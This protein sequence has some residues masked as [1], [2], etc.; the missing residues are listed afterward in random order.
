MAIYETIQMIEANVV[1]VNVGLASSMASFLLAAGTKGKRFSLRDGQIMIHQPQELLPPKGLT[2]PEIEIYRKEVQYLIDTLNEI[3]ARNVGKSVEQIKTDT[4]IDLWM[5]AEE[6]KNYGIVDFV[7]D[8]VDSIP[9]KLLP[10]TA[11]P[12]PQEK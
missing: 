11:A 7:V 5:S 2:N 6:A 10:S 4:M 8:D 9:D 1:T 12:L 3:F